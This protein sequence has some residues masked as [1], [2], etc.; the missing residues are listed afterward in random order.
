MQ[1][2]NPETLMDRTVCAVGGQR[3]RELI[4][5]NPSFDNADYVFPS[6]NILVELK[7]LEKDFLNDR[8]VYEKMHILYNRWVDEG[9]DVPI[10]YGE[11]I[12]RTDQIPAEY[13]RELIGIFK[14]RLESSV[15][16]KANRQIRET[17]ENLDYPDALGLLLLSNEGNFAFDGEMVAHVLMHSLGSKFSSIEHVILFSANL[18][19]VASATLP[20]A[21][22]FISIHFP[23]RRQ[24]TDEFLHKLGSSWYE[25]LGAATGKTFPPFRISTPTCAEIAVLRFRPPA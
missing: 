17:K 9:K 2:I 16:R 12:L 20:S 6:E 7:S 18:R 14:D 8:T 10:V 13:A 21:S 15:L 11:D 23:N 3:I 19:V 25:V 1:Q 24:P 5:V 22:P 4:G